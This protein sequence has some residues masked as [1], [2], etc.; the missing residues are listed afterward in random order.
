MRA[1]YSRCV[2][3]RPPKPDRR[4]PLVAFLRHSRRVLSC[5]RA[6]KSVIVV[7]RAKLNF[8]N[9]DHDLLLPSAS[10]AFYLL[11]LDTGSFRSQ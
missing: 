4:F 6:G 8:L 9:G 1:P 7:P 10:F 5:D 2:I 3:S 11:F